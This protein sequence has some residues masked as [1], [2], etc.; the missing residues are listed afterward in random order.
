MGPFCIFST[1][2][3]LGVCTKKNYSLLS[4][5]PAGPPHDYNLLPPGS[6]PGFVKFIPSLKQRNLP[7]TTVSPQANL[8][9]KSLQFPRYWNKV[10]PFLATGFLQF[11]Q[12]GT[13]HPSHVYS[14][15]SIRVKGRSQGFTSGPS[16]TTA[17]LQAI[18]L[19]P[20]TKNPIGSSREPFRFAIPINTGYRGASVGKGF[21]GVQVAEMSAG[22]SDVVGVGEAP[23][24]ETK[25]T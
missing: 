22:S 20:S 15:P 25:V 8:C 9:G 18:S 13:P 2:A 14:K 10:V 24:V 11:I 7:S 21:R 1:Q 19:A 4:R 16:A 12:V 17:K 5:C 6:S 3:V 23:G